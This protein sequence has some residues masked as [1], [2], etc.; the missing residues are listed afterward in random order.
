MLSPQEAKLI[1]ELNILNKPID[2]VVGT[3]SS[4]G[5]GPG[6]AEGLQQM[7]E[8]FQ[9]KQRIDT[10]NIIEEWEKE[11]TNKHQVQRKLTV[12]YLTPIVTLKMCAHPSS[13]SKRTWIP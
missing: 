12:L 9:W 4:S 10:A 8:K 3:T 11:S 7:K 6:M 13:T 2:S 5:T 1:V